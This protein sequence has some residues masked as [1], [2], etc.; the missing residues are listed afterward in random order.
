MIWLPL[1]EMAI[2]SPIMCLVDHQSHPIYFY[3][4]MIPY[5]LPSFAFCLI[6]VL[7]GIRSLDKPIPALIVWLSILRSQSDSRSVGRAVTPLLGRSCTL[8][9]RVDSVVDPHVLLL[10]VD[11]LVSPLPIRRHSW[12]AWP[13]TRHSRPLSQGGRGLGSWLPLS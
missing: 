7:I 4:M 11:E 5:V 9:P 12:A 3:E 10:I 2:S 13:A 1:F 6:I 8:P